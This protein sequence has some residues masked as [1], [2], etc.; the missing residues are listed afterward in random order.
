MLV[1][2]IILPYLIVLEV[3]DLTSS[4]PRVLCQLFD[5]KGRK[6]ASIVTKEQNQLELLK[7]M[8]FTIIREKLKYRHVLHKSI[9]QQF[10]C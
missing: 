7:G 6:E 9:W 10:F 8:T 5:D 3:Q 2:R 1:F 4:S